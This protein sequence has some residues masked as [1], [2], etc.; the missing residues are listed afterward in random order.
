MSWLSNNHRFI[1]EG[2][3]SLWIWDCFHGL[4]NSFDCSKYRQS[5]D[6][7]SFNGYKYLL[8]S[9][10][11]Q[12]LYLHFSLWTP[13]EGTIWKLPFGLSIHSKGQL[14]CLYNLKESTLLKNVFNRTENKTLKLSISCWCIFSNQTLCMKVDNDLPRCFVIGHIPIIFLFCCLTT[15]TNI[16]DSANSLHNCR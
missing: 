12:K 13:L 5:P 15:L 10:I 1:F 8:I 6:P 11:S 2:A 3:A 9:H 7:V 4:S 16:L 14:Y